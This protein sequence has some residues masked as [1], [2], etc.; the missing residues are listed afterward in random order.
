MVDYRRKKIDIRSVLVPGDYRQGMLF[1]D[2][3]TD[4][5]QQILDLADGTRS[6]A[7]IIRELDKPKDKILPVVRKFAHDG[8]LM[9]GDPEDVSSRCADVIAVGRFED[10]IELYRYILIFKR[11]DTAV[12][13]SLASLYERTA[14]TREAAQLYSQLATCYKKTGL[15]G[16]ALLALRKAA[17]LQPGN[18]KLQEELASLCVD[19]GRKDEAARIWRGYSLRLAGAGEYADALK[20]IDAAVTRIGGN[21]TLFYAEAEILALMEGKGRESRVIIPEDEVSVQKTGSG[22]NDVSEQSAVNITDFDYDQDPVFIQNFDTESAFDENDDTREEIAESGLS[23]PVTEEDNE[24]YLFTSVSPNYDNIRINSE[25]SSERSGISRTGGRV[26]MGILIAILLLLLFTGINYYYRSRMYSAVLESQ[27][28]GSL[29]HKSSLLEKV[30]ISESALRVL[31]DNKP[32]FAFMFSSEYSTQ[33]ARMLQLVTETRDELLQ[34]NVEF[35]KVAADWELKHTASLASRLLQYSK[36]EGIDTQRR[37]QARNLY[38]QWQ[39]EQDERLR[40][41]RDYIDVLADLQLNPETRFAAYRNLLLNYPEA[42]DSVYPEGIKNLTVPSRLVAEIA[43]TRSPVTLELKGAERRD[44]GL[45]EIP[46]NPAAEVFIQ[47]RG[48]SLGGGAESESSK[49]PYPLTYEQFFALEKAPVLNLKADLKFVPE[50]GG[51]FKSAK[52]VLLAGEAAY[53]LLSSVTG[54]I[55][56]AGRLEGSSSDT[57]FSTVDIMS[58]ADWAGVLVHGRLYTGKYGADNSL[59]LTEVPLPVGS[60]ILA[61]AMVDIESGRYDGVGIIRSITDSSKGVPER[62]VDLIKAKDGISLW[63]DDAAVK[64]LY[65]EISQPVVYT[66]KVSWYYLLVLRTG[67]VL[68]VLENGDIYKSFDIP[69]EPGELLAHGDVEQL[70]VKSESYILAG[71]H[72]MKFDFSG[73]PALSELWELDKGVRSSSLSAEGVITLTATGMKLRRISDGKIVMSYDAAAEIPFAPVSVA[74]TIY[75]FDGSSDRTRG[76]LVALDPGKKDLPKLWEYTLTQPVK[77]MFGGSEI[78]Y[79]VTQDGH[80]LGF[81]R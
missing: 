44:D 25:A 9:P 47:H 15:L 32:P 36:S 18:F 57:G 73:D 70:A 75:V 77:L 21:D 8:Y 7:G 14:H 12:M 29:L 61:G 54:K 1:A 69:L 49:M 11:D 42:F 56:S 80:I 74:G 6:V 64:R 16:D 37:V 50:A 68:L 31:Q 17:G 52:G 76:K 51:E 45:W 34:N 59:A 48:Y 13:S 53:S 19:T 4:M 65:R 58:C 35:D 2:A 60:E 46:V 72:I 79:L 63:G 5:Q 40:Q 3:F 22:S 10:G 43:R 33:L 27:G 66:G 20:V 81:D 38:A 23:E 28:L 41:R 39:Q 26:F 62:P 30:K 67:R 24:G 78:L 55:L 71:R